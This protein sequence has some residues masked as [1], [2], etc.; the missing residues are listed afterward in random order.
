M[1]FFACILAVLLICA[2]AVA[3][4]DGNAHNN[5]DIDNLNI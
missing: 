2:A 1:K 3:A 5:T 4:G